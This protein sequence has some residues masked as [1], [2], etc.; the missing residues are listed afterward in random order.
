MIVE[1]RSTSWQQRPSGYEF[2]GQTGDADVIASVNTASANI[3]MSSDYYISAH[4]GHTAG[5]GLN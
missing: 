3:T 2:A 4:F 5:P 1:W